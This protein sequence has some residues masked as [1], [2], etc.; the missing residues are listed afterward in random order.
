MIHQ[1][2]CNHNVLFMLFENSR[3]WL[4]QSDFWKINENS[5]FS[6]DSLGVKYDFQITIL[7]IEEYYNY[8]I[9]IIFSPTDVNTWYVDT[10]FL[11]RKEQAKLYINS[12]IETAFIEQACFAKH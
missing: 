9:L 11:S 6:S 4:Q 8:F 10:L 2:K 7:H 12:Y 5:D 3:L 1:P